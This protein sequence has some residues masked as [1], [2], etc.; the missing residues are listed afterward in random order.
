MPENREKRILVIRFSAMGDVA[1]TA[2]VVR[3]AAEQNPDTSFLFLTRKFF[4][5]FFAGIPRCEAIGVDL[6]RHGGIM[7]VIGIF[8][9]LRRH[10]AID[11]VI[12]L[13]DVLRT[14]QLR[15]F[16]KL[17]GVPVTVIDKGREEKKALTRQEN[18]V[19][20]PLIPTCERYRD[21]FRRAGLYVDK[22][23]DNLSKVVHNPEPIPAPI[24][25]RTGPKRG[26]WIGIAPFAQHKG[27][28]YPLEKM[29]VVIDTLAA[30][31]QNRLFIFSGGGEEKE[32]AQELAAG[33][34]N[35]TAVFGLVRLDGELALIS[36]LDCM[37]SMD[38][39]AMHMAA[40]K[41]IKTVSVWGATHR[42]AGFLGYGQTDEGV[43]EAEL[44]CRPCSIYGKKPC[45]RG[46]YAC[47][48]LIDPQRIV[49]KVNSFLQA[50]DK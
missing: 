13:H 3:E 10:Y 4:I 23:V 49:D 16:F 14:R 37:V 1:M 44:S 38:S 43:V 7:G 5:P 42:Y 50:V 27:K 46:D 12:D 25:E 32:K 41:G 21:A 18:K 26:K 30:D 9:Q 31:P 29:A 34:E 17:F 45:M 8:R 22:N 48:E 35:V 24:L 47:M 20:A 11:R 40:L 2:P 19:F 28:I 33:R 39:S 36:N 6:E 15:F